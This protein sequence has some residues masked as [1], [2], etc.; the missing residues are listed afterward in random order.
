MVF[1]RCRL[2]KSTGF[3][4]R[5]T[6]CSSACAE[7]ASSSAAAST[8]NMLVRIF[9]HLHKV[10]N[11][12]SNFLSRLS[13]SLLTNQIAS[14]L[15]SVG[16]GWCEHAGVSSGRA[17]LV[18]MR[19]VHDA[20]CAMLAQP[21]CWCRCPPPI[22]TLLGGLLAPKGLLFLK[23]RCNIISYRWALCNKWGI[24]MQ[25]SSK[26]LSS[27]LADLDLLCPPL[28]LLCLSS[29]LTVSA[30][31]AYLELAQAPKGKWRHACRI[32]V[33]CPCFPVS[34]LRA[35]LW[36]TS[37]AANAHMSP[38]SVLEVEGC[39]ILAAF[40]VLHLCVL[41]CQIRPQ[42]HMCGHKENYGGQCQGACGRKVQQWEHHEP[43]GHEQQKQ[44]GHL[45][46]TLPEAHHV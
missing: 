2:V 3:F 45:E 20:A 7:A 1:G 13:S 19:P 22:S 12:S 34:P 27:N 42:L 33:C 41:D 36:L 38:H 32:P 21:S 6:L 37:A 29:A 31:D 40:P 17:G 11:E 46:A 5:E 25:L 8:H 4:F 44:V 16:S 23:L 10:R 39:D 26:P 28:P 18:A 43:W 35:I 30:L 9:L 14:S 24:S 15:R